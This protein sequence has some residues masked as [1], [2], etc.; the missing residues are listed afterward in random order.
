ME[1]SAKPLFETHESM[2]LLEPQ[3][4]LSITLNIYLDTGEAYG[5]F[6]VF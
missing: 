5:V 6:T 1:F 3:V 4:E 2:H